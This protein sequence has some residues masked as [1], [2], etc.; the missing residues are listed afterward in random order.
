MPAPE[1]QR[2]AEFLAAHAVVLLG[3]GTLAILLSLVA[4]V[5]AV[6]G[7]ARFRQPLREG[8]ETLVDR[9]RQASV[10]R[11]FLRGASR[12]LPRGYLL[13]HFALGLAL[14]AAATLFVIVAEEVVSGDEIAVF[15]IAF[16]RALRDNATP[17]WERVF[18]RVSWLGRGDVL[19]VATLLV[20]LGLIVEDRVTIA[21]GWVAAQAGGGLLNYTL[22]QGFG[23]TRPEFADPLLAASSWSFP[24]GHVMGTFI[25]CG[26]ASYLL[27]RYVR[28]WTV[29]A[30]TVTVS[31]A[32]CLV[33][34]FSRLY[35]GV[36]FA[37]DVIA[38]LFAGGAW[39]AVCVSAFEVLRRRG[40]R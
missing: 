10:A 21:L 11:Q 1:I 18:E 20:A 34:A 31:L 37:S 30:A 6:R 39:V 22:K 2:A 40:E 32:W 14:T 28:S 9:V 16:A 3:L 36:H 4:I 33:M 19:G 8:F 38:G 12:R 35:L 5:L 15:D 17:E 25:F 13:V 26:L 23:R 7:I 27:L 29:A 24:S